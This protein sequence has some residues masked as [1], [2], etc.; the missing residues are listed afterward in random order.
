MPSPS[1]LTYDWISALNDQ[2]EWKT[3]ADATAWLMQLSRQTIIQGNKDPSKSKVQSG[4]KDPSERDP[5]ERKYPSN[6]VILFLKELIQNIR[7]IVYA[8]H[9]GKEPDLRF[10]EKCVSSLKLT[11]DKSLTLKA[12]LNNVAV[13]EPFSTIL[14]SM[15]LS[16]ANDLS[17]S[18]SKKKGI[19]VHRCE[20]LFR[21]STD[22]SRE[23]SESLWR[24]EI[25]ALAQNPPQN[26]ADIQRCEDLFIPRSRS[27]Y[28]S[29]TCRFSTFQ[30]TKQLHEPEY[31]A[32]KQRRYRQKKN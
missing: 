15:I 31:L 10:L 3:D 4:S 2:T 25:P 5:A 19:F 14:G 13:P 24:Q 17:E 30:I 8:L 32:D 20:G 7:A 27:K 6:E 1:Q 12:S 28:C 16:F 23:P 18:Q 11:F 29:D 26:V 9:F 22:D 21:N